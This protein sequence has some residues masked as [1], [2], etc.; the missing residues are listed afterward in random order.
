MAN[1]RRTH[2]HLA[3]GRDLFYY[4]DTP[5]YASGARSAGSTTP[6]P[7]G[8]VSKREPPGPRCVSTC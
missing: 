1:V 7:S 2:T 8:R 6:G 3:D 4:D 5:E